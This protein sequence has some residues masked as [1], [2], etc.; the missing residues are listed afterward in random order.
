MMLILA[1]GV[2]GLA[3]LSFHVARQDPE[4]EPASSSGVGIIVRSD[5]IHVWLPRRLTELAPGQFQ[6][7]S[8]RTREEL[9]RLLELE[10]REDLWYALTARGHQIDGHFAD[11][12]MIRRPYDDPSHF[13]E[14]MEILATIAGAPS[15]HAEAD[16]S[17]ASVHIIA[18]DLLEREPREVMAGLLGLPD[19]AADRGARHDPRAR[20]D[21]DKTIVV[22]ITGSARIAAAR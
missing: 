8:I 1:G 10:G 13:P 11:I 18:E 4:L 9:R 3:R 20:G 19:P 21:H 2:I 17:R 7:R 16:F 15:R 5:T 12:T 6:S 14:L 22:N